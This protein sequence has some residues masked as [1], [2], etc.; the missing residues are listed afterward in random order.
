MDGVK[1][2]GVKQQKLPITRITEN[3]LEHKSSPETDD[4]RYFDPKLIKSD[5]SNR[6]KIPINDA[7]VFVIG[8]GNY[9][10]Y[11]NLLDNSKVNFIF[12]IQFFLGGV[13]FN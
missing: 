5:G 12:I 6:S 4:Y 9:F 10:E 7:I 3:L 2:L 11:Q 8:G 1:N 13:F